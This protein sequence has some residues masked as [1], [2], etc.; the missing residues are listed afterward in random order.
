MIA[1]ASRLAYV[2]AAVIAIVLASRTRS[3]RAPAAALSL[4][5]V[6]DCVRPILGPGRLDVALFAA[7]PAVAVWLARG[8]WCVAWVAYGL[9]VALFGERLGPWPWPL[10]YSRVALLVLAPRR[11]ESSTRVR[12]G[13][14]LAAGQIAGVVV[15]S[16][17]RHDAGPSWAE[18][19]AQT[20]INAAILVAI[21]VVLVRARDKIA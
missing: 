7:W 14:L 8:P 13:L 2:A 6:L 1:H 9:A 4:L 18:R 10:A 20:M 21:V 16:W 12:V 17:P 19:G 3:L 5:A 15:R 11:W